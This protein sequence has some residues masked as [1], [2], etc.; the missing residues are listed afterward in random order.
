MPFQ[1]HTDVTKANVALGSTIKNTTIA[2]A[3]NFISIFDMDATAI[4]IPNTFWSS[5][6][7]DNAGSDQM[8]FYTS[9]QLWPNRTFGKTTSTHGISPSCVSSSIQTVP[10]Q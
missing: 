8:F 7:M 2:V 4:G 5:K 10:G 6:A 3:D 9:L 1:C